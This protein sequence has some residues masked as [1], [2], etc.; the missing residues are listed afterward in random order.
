M[1]S[2]GWSASAQCR[3]RGGF[4]LIELLV[5]VAILALLISLLLPAL[6]HARERGQETVC[7]T[8]LRTMGQAALI[9]AQENRDRVVRSESPWAHFAIMLLPHI[10]QPDDVQR[11]F[12]RNGNVIRAELQEICR[13]TAILNCPRFPVEAQLLDYVVSA[14]QIPFPFRQNDFISETVGTGPRSTTD[15]R[16]PTFTDINN[17]GARSASQFIYVTEAHQGMPLPDTPNWAILTDLFLPNHLPL[18]GFPRVANDQRH[19][20]GVGCM[21]FDGRAEML[22]VRSI[23]P[24]GPVPMRE[25]MRR[26]TYDELE[27][28]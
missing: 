24:G 8:N 16:R 26:F 19:P 20:G 17:M 14:F 27:G 28:F 3:A 10:G 21:F 18:A 13:R 4:T 23:D 1:W 5:V 7:L 11:L 12:D 6:S 9:Y 15:D 22:P 2:A 25:R